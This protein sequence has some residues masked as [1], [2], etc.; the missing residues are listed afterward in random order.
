MEGLTAN[1]NVSFIFKNLQWNTNNNN[2]ILNTF[3]L[4][5]KGIKID[6]LNCISI[7]CVLTLSF[8]CYYLWV[9]ITAQPWFSFSTISLCVCLLTLFQSMNIK[10]N[11]W[12][13]FLSS[14][15]IL[16]KQYRYWEFNCTVAVP[17]ST[18]V[19]LCI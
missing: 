8:L 13:H 12:Y 14:K 4:V 18:N 1:K 19:M 10:M 5:K 3:I 6:L 7:T 11:Y 15:Q 16:L 2:F 17:C 9:Y